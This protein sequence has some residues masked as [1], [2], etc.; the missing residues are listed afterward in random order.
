MNIP[1]LMPQL[2]NETTEAELTEWLKAVGDPVREGEQILIVTTTKLSM[3]IE[4]PATGVLKD[5]VVPEGDIAEIGA[6]LAII[7][8]E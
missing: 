5:I 2:G 7:A 6:T 1:L 8:T 3:E 4:A